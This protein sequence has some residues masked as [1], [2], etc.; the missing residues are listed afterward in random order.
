L[1]ADFPDEVLLHPPQETIGEDRFPKCEAESG[2]WP[3]W[4]LG[5]VTSDRLGAIT[6]HYHAW[7]YGLAELAAGGNSEAADRLGRTVRDWIDRCPVEEAGARQLAWNAYAVATRISS[8]VRTYR[9]LRS[10]GPVP[11]PWDDAVPRS[12]W[13]QAA[14]LSDNLEWDLRANHLLR[15]AVGLAFAGRFFAGDRPADWLRSATRLGLDQVR[16]QFLPDGGH[17]ERSPMYHLHAMEDARS[18]AH[19]TDDADAGREFRAAWQ[20][21]AE[22]AAW[23]RHPDGRIP[24]LNDAALNGATDPGNVLASAATLG[25]EID[26]SP[27]RGGRFFPDTGLVVWHGDPWS[28]FFDVGPV[29]PDYQPGHGHADTLTVECSYR[30]RRLVVDPGT[31]SYDQGPDRHYDRSTAAHNTVCV[32]GADSSEVWH[33]F[34]VGR[35]ASPEAVAVELSPRAVRA[36]AAHDG[37]RFLPGRP[38]H[39]RTL[40]VRDGGPLEITDRVDG[41]R[42]HALD[43]GWLIGPDWAVEPADTGWVVSSDGDRVRVTVHGPVGVQR[44]VEPRPY[45][46]EFGRERTATRL[47]WR[48]AGELP[49]EVVTVVEPA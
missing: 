38:R 24:L 35:R 12:L 46:A 43:G 37:Y 33:I 31:L 27:Q 36:T 30:G 34:R 1:R 13:E 41:G 11:P 40:S 16:E 10:A 18:L 5:T 21:A 2:G 44:Y 32:D 28:A 20:R 45:H 14:Y 25:I 3:D 47:G 23:L 8:W 22:F 15:D 49:V 17:F 26:G 48:F 7:A 4:R 29:G 9:R 39:T 19:L 42:S 6:L